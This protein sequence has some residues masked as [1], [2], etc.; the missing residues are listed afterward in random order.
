[1]PPIPGCLHGGGN[2]AVPN[3]LGERGPR[4]AIQRLNTATSASLRKNSPP[5]CS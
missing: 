1:M 5:G 3:A 2:V 4:Y